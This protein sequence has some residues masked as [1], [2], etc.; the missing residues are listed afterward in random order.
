MFLSVATKA[1]G[2]RYPA[3]DPMDSY[4]KYLEYPEII[5]YLNETIDAKW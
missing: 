4:S 3:I 2:K 1:D 5:D